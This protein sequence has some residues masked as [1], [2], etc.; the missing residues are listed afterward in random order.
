MLEDSLESKN[1]LAYAD[2]I[3]FMCLDE[4]IKNVMEKLIET[5]DKYGLKINMQKTKIMK[6]S[7]SRGK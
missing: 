5:S 1:V 2:D 4:Q 7:Q 3:A 6:I